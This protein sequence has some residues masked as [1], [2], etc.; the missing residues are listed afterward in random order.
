MRRLKLL[1]MIAALLALM[2]A[3]VVVGSPY[4]SVMTAAPENIEQIWAIEDARQESSVP[5]VTALENNGVPMAYDAAMNTFYCTLG[6]DNADAWPEIHITAPEAPGVCLSFVDDYSYDWC[7]DALRDGYAYQGI[8]YTDTEFAYFDV[9]FTGL[10]QLCI[11]TRGQEITIEDSNVDVTMA[12]YGEAPLVSTGRMHL[13]GAST[14]IFDKKSSKLEFTREREGNAKKIEVNVPGFGRADDLALLPCWHDETKMRDKLNWDMWAQL[15]ADGEPFGAR[16]TGYVE[17]FMN[18]EYHGLYLMVEPV[19]I[20]GELALAGESRLLTDS[21]YRTAA[22]NFARDREYLTH[23]HRANAGYELYY[24]P[25]GAGSYEARF[26]ALMPYVELTKMQD[27]AAFAERALKLF[28]IDSMLRYALMMQGG[29]IA[30]NF[31]NNMYIWAQYTPQGVQYRFAPWDLDVA[32]GFE[33]HEIGEEY[34][35]WLFFPVLDRMLN[36]D[37]GGI[38]RRAYDMWQ[39]MR[40]GIFSMEYLEGK[41][42][43][44][45]Q[46]LGESGA[47]MRDAERWGNFMT[48]PDG[49]E[50]ITFAQMRWPLLDEAMQRLVDTDGPVD[51]LT[52]SNYNQKAGDIRAAEPEYDE[53][54]WEEDDWEETWQEEDDEAQYAENGY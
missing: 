38:R 28:D 46:L 50:L 54:F 19:D 49:Y 14:L 37:V 7:V 15:N 43:E 41:I 6:T 36:L 39:Q 42:A 23:P 8:A 30:D 22:L 48:Y 16:K 44:Y 9:V 25:S 18:G 35:R 33:R 26:A 29:A 51:F 5:L 3:V 21:V 52:R 11:D 2:A 12:A 4:A 32:W 20:A 31:F 10:P 34:E 47:L 45:T 1:L 27:D 17:V 53:G 13:R 24:A 40:G